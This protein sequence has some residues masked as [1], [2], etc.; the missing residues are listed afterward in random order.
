MIKKSRLK[1][2]SK[3]KKHGKKFE[4]EYQERLNKKNG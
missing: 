3:S 1:D 4:I 2:Q